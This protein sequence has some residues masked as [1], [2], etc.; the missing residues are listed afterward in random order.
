MPANAADRSLRR[1]VGIVALLNLGYFGVEFAVALAI[2]SVSLFADS[3]D[4][5]E[6]ASVNLLILIALGWSLK[7]R[8]RV[9]M[10]LAAILLV[11]ALATLWALWSKFQLPAPPAPLPLTATG[12]GA[13]LVNFSCAM[14]LVRFRH[15]SGSLTR[16][17][18]LSARN[19]V[20]ANIAI[21]IA[22]AATAMTHA[23]WPDMVVGAGIM[24]MNADA[25]REIWQAARSEHREATGPHA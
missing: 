15:H 19:D 16:A 18:F 24:L 13:M 23:A 9:G 1:V 20:L 22:G 25:A 4:F 14:L 5:L 17:A 10:G 8:A 21:I 3:V 12:L 2:G 6:D 7:A 11:P